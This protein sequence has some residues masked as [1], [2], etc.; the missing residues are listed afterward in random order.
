[1]K[2]RKKVFLA[3]VTIILLVIVLSSFFSFNITG[4]VISLPGS[5]IGE[6]A[7][8]LSGNAIF[9]RSDEIIFEAPTPDQG[10]ILDST[11]IYVNMTNTLALDSYSFVD[12]SDDILGWWKFEEVGERGFIEDVSGKGNN[13]KLIGLAQ[14]KI[15]PGKF[16]EARGIQRDEQITYF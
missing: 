12:V 11:S 3:F 5:F 8:F 6:I 4:N 16:G 14:T 15:G 10:S 1:M 13:A 2:R 9:E 7:S